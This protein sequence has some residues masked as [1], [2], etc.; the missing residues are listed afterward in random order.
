MNDWTSVNSIT[1][2]MLTM[3]AH[4]VIVYCLFN[5]SHIL[6]CLLNYVLNT[7]KNNQSLLIARYCIQLCTRYSSWDSLKYLNVV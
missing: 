4:T 5:S 3:P 6:N 7:M 1:S 2:P